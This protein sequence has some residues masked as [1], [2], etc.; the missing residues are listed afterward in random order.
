MSVSLFVCVGAPGRYNE[1]TFGLMRAGDRNSTKF[2]DLS[3]LYHMRHVVQQYTL[4]G[5][6]NLRFP[7]TKR[8]AQ[9][10]SAAIYERPPGPINWPTDVQMELWLDEAIAKVGACRFSFCCCF[11]CKLA[12]HTKHT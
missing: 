6:T 10:A 3:A 5:D 2:R 9:R 8:G 4:E 12:L 1:F 11:R 7:P